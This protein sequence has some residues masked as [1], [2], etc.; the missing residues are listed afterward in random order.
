MKRSQKPR[1]DY[2]K[3]VDL[4][5]YRRL[6]R[7]IR[8][9][10]PALSAEHVLRIL[11][12]ADT[13]S[14]REWAK[15]GQRLKQALAG[16]RTCTL[17]ELI[18]YFVIGWG[19]KSGRW[20]RELLDGRRYTNEPLW[21]GKRPPTIT[22][23]CRLADDLRRTLDLLLQQGAWVAF[24]CIADE[25]DG[26]IVKKYSWV[27]PRGAAGYSRADEE[28]KDN[29]FRTYCFALLARLLHEG[30][31]WRVTQ[32]DQCRG[33]F[34]KTRRDPPGRPSRFCSEQCRRD[35]HNPRRPK[36]GPPQ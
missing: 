6:V 9:I 14:S 8:W 20:T 1:K 3:R 21:L 13:W 12:E 15:Q 36:K 25:I 26:R 4:A 31:G 32:C 23:L 19:R 35:W 28:V 16:E 5:P 10:N 30:H 7:F 17:P 24:D 11:P 29:D 2:E 18:P 34:L 33:F 22:G 27:G